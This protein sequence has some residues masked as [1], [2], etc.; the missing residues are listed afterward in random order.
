MERRSQWRTSAK[1]SAGSA[2]QMN[3]PNIAVRIRYER[4]KEGERLLF[5]L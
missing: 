3:Q 4:E 1:L 2:R 5:G